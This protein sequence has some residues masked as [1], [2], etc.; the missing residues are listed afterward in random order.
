MATLFLSSLALGIAFCAPPGA[1][2]AEALRRG[3]ARGFRPVLLVE[4]GSLVGDATWALVALAGVAFVVQN[5]V[6]RLLLGSLGTLFLLHLAWSAIRSAKQGVVPQAKNGSNRGDFAVGALLSLGNPFAV[7]FWLGVGTS[8][9]AASI[10][11]PHWTH[12]A[13]FFLAFMSG[14]VAWCFFFAGLVTWGRRFVNSGFFR[15]VNLVCG[16]FLA[17]FGLQ[18]AWSTLQGLLF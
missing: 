17:Y 2:T 9:I 6:A 4:L 8:T 12:L 11:N 13:V 7:A 14:A 18:L 16:L 3:L 10:P 15:G 5:S 1:V